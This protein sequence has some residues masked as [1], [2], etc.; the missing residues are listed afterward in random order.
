MYECLLISSKSINIY[1]IY[2]FLKTKS[3]EL[4]KKMIMKMQNERKNNVLG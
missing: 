2:V 3:I 4:S 1:R